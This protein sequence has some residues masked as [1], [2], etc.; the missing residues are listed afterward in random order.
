MVDN[1]DSIKQILPA[2]DKNLP[3]HLLNL[4]F[5]L[6]ITPSQNALLLWHPLTDKPK[7]R[8]GVSITSQLRIVAKC[9]IIICST[10]KPPILLF[11]K[12]TL[13]PEES[14]KQFRVA[15]ILKTL[16]TFASQK[17]KVSSTYYNMFTFTFS[18]PVSK[19]SIRF[20][21]TAILDTPAIPYAAIRN[22]NGASR[23]PCRSLFFGKN[24]LVGLSFT[25]MNM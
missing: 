17:Y 5:I 2:K 12:F 21:S 10:P 13:S 24:S 11:I 16:L 9:C 18:L 23:S 8:K 1:T 3:F 15:F 25:R 7:Y 6:T 19:L 14:S 20:F 22:K 4:F